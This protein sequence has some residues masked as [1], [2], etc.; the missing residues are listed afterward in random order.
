MASVE[1]IFQGLGFPK[2]DEI[3]GFIKFKPL[4]GK[5]GAGI[6]NEIRGSTERR[7]VRRKTERPIRRSKSMT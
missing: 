6:G 2:E 4:I 7:K 1:V 5:R 3:P